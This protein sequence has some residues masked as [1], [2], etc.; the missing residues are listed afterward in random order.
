MSGVQQFI[1]LQG[2]PIAPASDA[3]KCPL[4]LDAEKRKVIRAGYRQWRRRISR[5]SLFETS[6]FVPF[7]VIVLLAAGTRIPD[8]PFPGMLPEITFAGCD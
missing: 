5:Q 2:H 8:F 6:S 1:L 4:S 3:N 7:P